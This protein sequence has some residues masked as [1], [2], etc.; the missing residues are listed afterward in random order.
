MED[1]ADWCVSSSP[2]ISIGVVEGE[3]PYLLH[4]VTSLRVTSSGQLILANAGTREVRIF[5]SNGA[6]W[7]PWADGVQ[8]PENTSTLLASSCLLTIR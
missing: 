5:D 4:D 6:W 3:E 1:L 7:G 2:I 8:V